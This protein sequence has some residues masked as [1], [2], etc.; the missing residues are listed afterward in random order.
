MKHNLLQPIHM[1]SGNLLIYASES[2][3]AITKWRYGPHYHLELTKRNF[4]MIFT[5][6]SNCFSEN[7]RLWQSKSAHK[8][9]TNP[10]LIYKMEVF[11]GAASDAILK[12]IMVKTHS[13]AIVLR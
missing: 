5:K 4:V 10:N 13:V 8:H 6:S 9:V 1:R 3:E 7:T 12:L 11:D 2:K